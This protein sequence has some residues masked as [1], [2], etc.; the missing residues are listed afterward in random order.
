MAHFSADG[1]QVILASQ[2]KSFHVYDM[3]KGD[4]TRI[5]GI[6]GNLKYFLM[7][8]HL[9]VPG[10]SW[11]INCTYMLLICVPNDKIQPTMFW[12]FQKMKEHFLLV[13]SKAK[14]STKANLNW[15]LFPFRQRSREIFWQVSCF[16]RW[17]ASHICR[18]WW[19]FN[20]SFKQGLYFSKKS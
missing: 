18:H 5:P 7:S 10:V 13:F 2:R 8:S 12:I 1:E 15:I 16:T 17:K 6:R 3:I 14:I 19:I 11:W 20:S 4:I 9:S